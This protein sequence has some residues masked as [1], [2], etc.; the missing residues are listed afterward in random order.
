MTL[1]LRGSSSG[2]VALD[3]PATAGD[4]TLTLPANNGSA[5][6]LLKT[7]GSGN[8]SWATVSE[9]TINNNA[10][11][12]VI[13]GSGT[14]NTLEGEA[15]LTFNGSQL[16]LN[17][18]S[19][20]FNRWK[21]DQ[22]RFN[23]TGTAHIDHYTT[24]QD[25]KFRVSG[26][27]A[28]DT[29][30]FEIKSNGNIKTNGNLIIGTA[31]KGIDFSV[32]AGSSA[33][34]A[35][36]S[37]ELLDHYEE[38]TWTP[39]FESTSTDPTY[40]NWHTTGTYIRIGGMCYIWFDPHE[41]TFSGTAAAGYG[42]ISGFPFASTDNGSLACG[43][44]ENVLKW[45]GTGNLRDAGLTM[46]SSN[47]QAEFNTAAPSRGFTWDVGNASSKGYFDIGGGYKCV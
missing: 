3:A 39:V 2:Y 24:G 38:G 8:L 40:S 20:T 11:N 15:N 5:N 22:L 47:A 37:S 33:T 31:G 10:D 35:S 4:N 13:T 6:Q 12:R 25:F 16:D 43:R 45:A 7:D 32:N 29:T 34:G 41:I 14:A 28:A 17:T 46:S 27:S 36:T 44:T 19:G 21:T 9:T 1:K 26:S 23:S 42:Y 30:A 18:G